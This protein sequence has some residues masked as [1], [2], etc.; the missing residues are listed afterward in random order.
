MSEQATSLPPEEEVFFIKN[1]IA[2]DLATKRPKTAIKRYNYMVKK[3]KKIEQ[4]YA[5]NEDLSAAFPFRRSVYEN[6]RKKG[7]KGKEKTR[8][9]GPILPIRKVTRPLSGKKRPRTTF[10]EEEEEE[11]FLPEAPPLL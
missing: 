4:V 1:L 5:M 10:I 3:L 7:R 2:Q 11:G 6:G 9:E 8:E